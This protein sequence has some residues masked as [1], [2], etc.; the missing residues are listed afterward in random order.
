MSKGSKSVFALMGA[1][2]HSEGER[3]KLDYY[4]TEPL[5]VELL[6]DKEEFSDV[7]TEPCCGEGHISKVLI[8]RGKQ[9]HSF[10]LVDRGFGDKKDFYSVT[11]VDGDIITNPP[12]KQALPFVKHALKT[13][14]AGHKV[15]MFLRLQ[16]LEGQERGHFFKDSP[17]TKV[18]VA[19]KRLMCAKNGDFKNSKDRAVAFAWFIW[20]KDSAGKIVKKAPTIDWIGND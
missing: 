17:P 8:N 1:S 5:A 18:L 9:V 15:A 16:F 14:K 11:K 2:N 10:D 4:A 7:I 6:L 13:V 12:Y 20:E 19:S 3:A